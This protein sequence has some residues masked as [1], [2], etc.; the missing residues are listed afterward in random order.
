MNFL[1]YPVS[2]FT[3][4]SVEMKLNHDLHVH[5][6]LSAC[7]ADKVNHKPAPILDLARRMNLST[8]GFADHVWMNPDLTPSGWYRP[9]DAS[10][11]ARLRQD[12]ASLA[13]PG[14]RVLVGCEADTVAPGKFSITPRFA[15][16]LDFVLLACSHLHMNGFVVQPPSRAPHDLAAHM[17]SLFRSAVSSG[18]ATSIPHPLLPIGYMD[19]FDAAI[20]SCSD[21]ELFDLFS[22][23]AHRGVALE[24]TV[25]FLPSEK[26][27]FSLE[28]PIRFLSI[29]RR[30]GCK[31]TFATDAH[32]PDDQRRLPEL[33]RLVDPLELTPDDLLPLVR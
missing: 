16:S 23:T 4:R 32:S 2:R 19:L 21:N 26:N 24:I 10:Q 8:L 9:Q 3:E 1:L 6:Y 14:L 33:A 22:F 5:T 12:L 29:A 20:A 11:I 28:T 7:C 15:E 30:A 18:F 31:F 25:G 17:I 27:P 13:S